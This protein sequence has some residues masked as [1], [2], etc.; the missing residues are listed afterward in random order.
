M[1]EGEMG[2][3]D[4]IELGKFRMTKGG[5]LHFQQTVHLPRVCQVV[6]VHPR[7]GPQQQTAEKVW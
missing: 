1:N 5:L 2:Y 7:L 3:N 4:I 6:V